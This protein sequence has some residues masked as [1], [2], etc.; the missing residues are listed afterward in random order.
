MYLPENLTALETIS[1]CSILL[2][3]KKTAQFFWMQK[4]ALGDIADKLNQNHR[5]L[6]HLNMQSQFGSKM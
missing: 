3:A 5:L 4:T 6:K 2:N 1:A